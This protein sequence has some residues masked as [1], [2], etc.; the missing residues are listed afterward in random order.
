MKK[1]KDYNKDLRSNILISSIRVEEAAS[2]VLVY[3]FRTIKPDSKTLGNKSSSLSLKNK[4]DLLYDLED[5]EKADYAGMIKFMEIRNQFIHNPNCSCFLDLSKDFPEGLK[6]LK[7]NYPVQENN[8]EIMYQTSFF[9][10]WKSV[11]GKLILLKFE[12]SKGAE[13]EMKRFVNSQSVMK[14][15]EICNL[16][17]ENWKKRKSEDENIP[18][19]GYTFDQLQHEIQVFTNQLQYDLLD[20]QIKVLDSIDD[21]KIVAKDIYRRKISIIEE[22]K[23]TELKH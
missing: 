5:I 14:F 13:E 21:N 6:Y 17:I 20:E 9:N 3:L 12:Y 16:A 1:V 7:T 22:L 11:L 10:L 2:N 23:K 8:A 4:I 18:F 15:N 19:L